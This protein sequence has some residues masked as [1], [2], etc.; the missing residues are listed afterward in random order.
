MQDI[1]ARAHIDLGAII[2]NA[3]QIKY[4]C[5]PAKFCA[6]V[7]ADAY[8]HGICEVA[9]S[10]CGLVDCFAVCSVQEGV[11]LR[12]VGIKNPILCL[13]PQYDYY[14][15]Y[16]YDLTLSL[17]SVND[18]LFAHEFCKKSGCQLKVQLAINTGMNRFGVNTACEIR[19][20]LPFFKCGYLQ[21]TGVYSHFYNVRSKGDNDLQL[22]QFKKL[23]ADIKGLFPNV[24]FHIS[25][26][27]GLAFGECYKLDMVRVGLM[28]YGYKS[29]D[30]KLRLK[31][32]MSLRTDF[33]CERT[34]E[35]GNP[36]LYGNFRLADDRNVKIAPFG[37]FN[38]LN[39]GLNGQLNNCAMN[40]CAV[41][42]EN[43]GILFDNAYKT[44]QKTGKTCYEVLISVGMNNPRVYYYGDNYENNCGKI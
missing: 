13:L 15:A 9:S 20:I 25:S 3:R 27:G 17:S 2:F 21:L 35:R 36:L 11:L 14:R 26:G 29:V 38:G 42:S 33:Y 24:T 1:K 40:V 34:L 37:Y 18:V 10:I 8:G 5:L 43:Y 28:L 39:T 7:K 4:A 23:S 41:G 22:E 16:F 32:A 30:C 31:M 12:Q 6:V 44:A 19:K